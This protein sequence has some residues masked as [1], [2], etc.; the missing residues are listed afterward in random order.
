MPI[1][2]A[3]AVDDEV[4]IEAPNHEE[5][6]EILCAYLG[7]RIPSALIVWTGVDALPE[8]EELIPD[9]RG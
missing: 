9:V 2:K 8:G 4:Y 7:D 6:Y 3:H 1:I 5:A